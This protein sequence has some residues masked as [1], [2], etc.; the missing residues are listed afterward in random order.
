MAEHFKTYSQYYDLLYRDKDYS[1]EANYV[2]ELI[3]RFD[4]QSQSVLELGCG[5]GKHAELLAGAGW[6]V[7]G[8]ELSTTMLEAAQQRAASLKQRTEAGSFDPHLGD[9]R[10]FRIDQTFGA[11]IS[12]FH[13]VSYQTSNDDAIRMFETAAAHLSAG[14]LFVFDVWYG[15]AVVAQKPVVRV[16]RMEDEH[17]K[18]IR[19][20]EPELFP[21]LNRVDVNYTVLA[22]SKSDGTVEQF[23]ECHP[24]RYFFQSEIDLLANLTGFEMVHAEEWMTCNEP[25]D[26]SWGVA[27][28]LRKTDRSR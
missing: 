12:L 28:V 21:D 2:S 15:P 1:G 18:V 16:K 6:Q 24:M 25:S 14:G 20:A 19:I 3:Q 7:T 9:A 27:F 11:V 4:P 22:T 17:L 26:Q 23:D 10:D 5:T 13:V 8:V